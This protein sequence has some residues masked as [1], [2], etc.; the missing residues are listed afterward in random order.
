MEVVLLRASMAED[1]SE[2]V[3]PGWLARR[4]LLQAELSSV[5]EKRLLVLVV[6]GVLSPRLPASSTLLPVAVDEESED[7][8]PVSVLLPRVS[9]GDS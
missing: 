7:S 9:L 4:L 8:P 6:L 5:Q 2:A 3:L 1:D